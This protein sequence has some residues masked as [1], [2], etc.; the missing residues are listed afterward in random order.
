MK[1]RGQFKEVHVR[2]KNDRGEEI[3]RIVRKQSSVEWEVRKYY[4][5]LYRHEETRSRKED[6][7]EK[8]GDVIRSARKKAAN[9]K[10]KLPWKK[11]VRR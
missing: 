2:E 8:I 7:L 3:V 10:R 6:I 11:S 5:N 9:L 1:S 4:W